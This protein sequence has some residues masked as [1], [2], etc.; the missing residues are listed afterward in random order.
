MCKSN[1]TQNLLVSGDITVNNQLY[2]SGVFREIKEKEINKYQNKING[3][4]Y[5]PWP[6]LITRN[7]TITF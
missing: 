6:Y 1:S 4:K 5:D 7:G 2:V 3:N